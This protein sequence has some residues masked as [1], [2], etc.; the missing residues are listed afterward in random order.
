[1]ILFFQLLGFVTAIYIIVVIF[2]NLKDRKISPIFYITLSVLQLISVIY[3]IINLVKTP[4]TSQWIKVI[5]YALIF[6]WTLYSLIKDLHP[7][8]SK[9]KAMDN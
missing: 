1:M 6:F 7:T 2:L 4:V 8:P 9:N 5:I 3:E